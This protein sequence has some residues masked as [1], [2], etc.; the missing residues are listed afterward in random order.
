MNSELMVLIAALAG[1][2][3]T[4][5]PSL[6]VE[7]MREHKRCDHVKAALQAEVKSLVQLVRTREY[8][9]FLDEALIRFEQP[10][11]NVQTLSFSAT[12]HFS[13][14][15]RALL[16][17]IGLLGK[18][19]AALLVEFHHLVEAITL[20]V[21]PGVGVLAVGAQKEGFVQLRSLFVRLMSLGDQIVQK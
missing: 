1:S 3:V 4:F 17:E 16:P 19:D 6:I 15:Y 13:A 20:D 18:E 8:V 14:V 9:R 7:K 2:L 21:Q 11:C 12:E 10:D 5:V